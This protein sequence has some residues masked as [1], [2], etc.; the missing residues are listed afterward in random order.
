MRWWVAAVALCWSVPLSAGPV[1][2]PAVDLQAMH[3]AMNA[4]QA[5]DTAYPSAASYAHFL[6]ARLSHHEGDHRNALDELRLALASDDSNPYL[7]TQLAE[8]LA[9]LSDLERAE[10]QLKRVLERFPDYPPAQLLMGRVLFEARKMTR[11]RVHLQKAMHLRPND[12][13]AY[14][15]LTQLCLDQGRVDDAIKVVDELGA[16]LPG[17]PIGYRRL[18]LALAERGEQAKAEK[19]LLRAVDRDPGDFEAWVTLARI[20]EAT[21]RR[22]KA[23]EAYGRALERDAENREVL[24]AAGRLALRM[25]NAA[26]ARAYFDQLLS[27]SRD[28]EQVV[29]VSFSYLAAQQLPAAVEVLDAARKTSDEPRLSFYAGLVHERLRAYGKAAEA[30]EAVPRAAGELYDE[31]RLHRAM[32]LSSAG[33][34]KAALELFK[35][36]HD[37]KADL[38]GLDAAWARAFERAGQPK[39]AE[40]LLLRAL[41]Q[42]P[43]APEVLDA[44]TSFYDRQNRLGDA[45]SLL[46][47]ALSRSPRDQALLFGLAS[48]LE[49]K[50]EW[51]KAV[52][53]M[54][55]VLESDPQNVAAMNFIGYTLAERGGDLD[56]AEKL[57]KKALETKPDSAAFLDSMGWVYF[58]RG[59]YGRAVEYLERAVDESPDEPTLQEHLADALKAAARRAQAAERYGRALELLKANPDGADRRAQRVEIEH[60]LKVLSSEP[61]GR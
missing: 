20:Y 54:R 17:E 27:L 32:C 56:E 34:H 41:A 28:P 12:P 9:R 2:R 10:G 3:E 35:K 18:G 46:S 44:I 53:K 29:K 4:S 52:E 40:A 30:F 24:L 31:A 59:E 16:A 37:D 38:S 50:G 55:L 48:T 49:R 61:A 39:E 47:G 1:K 5:P 23:L 43:A 7:M 21:N 58:K 6:Q 51:Q 15:V 25:D 13:D 19:L 33:Q 36:V 57:V 11:A 42:G 45:V 60:K 22:P 26:E 14:L 8:E